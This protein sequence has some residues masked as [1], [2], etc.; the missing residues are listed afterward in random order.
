MRA[1]SNHSDTLPAV[2]GSGYWTFADVEAR[3]IEAAALWKREESKGW[4]FAGD[5]PWSL[6]RKEWSDW[7]ARDP[8]PIK[9]GPASRAE[10]GRRDEASR[11]VAEHVAEKDRRL[12]WMVLAI[13]ATGRQVDWARV[14]RAMGLVRGIEGVRKRYSRSVHRVAK[15]LND[16]RVPVVRADA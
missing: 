6:I 4:P 5:G 2:E 16:A 7:D 11:W 15:A 8:K 10:T 14:V 13:K 3:L 12:V 9:L 1:A